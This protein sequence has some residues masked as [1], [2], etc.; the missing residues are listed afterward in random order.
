[1]NVSSGL[2]FAPL[3]RVPIY[4]ATK[5]ALHSFCLT[6]RHQLQDTN[7]KVFELIPPIVDTELNSEGRKKINFTADIKPAD[8]AAAMVEGIKN[9]KFEIGYGTAEGMR[10][11]SREE[12]DKRFQM[13]NRR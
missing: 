9:D 4:C 6:L 13:M 3:A 8:F 7:I 5:A 12:L 10:M 11:A 2:G 1:M